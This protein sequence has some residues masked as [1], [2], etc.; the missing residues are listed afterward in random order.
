MA[1]AHHVAVQLKHSIAVV[2]ATATHG[3]RTFLIRLSPSCWIC[4]ACM[5]GWCPDDCN[6][7]VGSVYVGAYM[8]QS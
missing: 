3:C 7:F 8:L 2:F 1:I 6:S 4:N 5:Q